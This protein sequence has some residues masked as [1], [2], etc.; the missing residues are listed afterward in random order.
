M[1][2]H[3]VL[4]RDRRPSQAAIKRQK[5]ALAA[6]REGSSARP[7]LR[8]LVLDPEVAK[9]PEPVAFEAITP[10]LDEDKVVAAANALGAEDLYLVEGPPGTGK[11]SFICELVNQYLLARPGDKVLLVSQMHVAID[12]AVTRLFE[13]GVT[14]VV[15]L[16]SRDDKVDPEASHLLLS[17][18]LD[19]W[20]KEIARR[21]QH[22]LSVL[23]EREGIQV[24]YVS[25]A[26]KAEEARAALRDLAERR[27]AL[28]VMESS[29]RLDNEDLSD[30]RA[31]LL[32]D[33]YRATERAEEATSVALE[34]ARGLG[35]DLGSDPG[36]SELVARV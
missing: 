22:G 17:N 1:P 2:Q 15:R 33:Y 25:L 26:L 14:N 11:T 23:A 12:N 6:L 35:E 10:E 21:A 13:S 34:T 29:D 18:K 8:E 20:T 27:E 9:C 4:V 19:A 36:D 28:G 32:A 30:E 3:G 24:E 16:S 31:T 5:T 7:H